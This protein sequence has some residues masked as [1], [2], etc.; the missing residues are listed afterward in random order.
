MFGLLWRVQRDLLKLASASYSGDPALGCR[1]LWR[2]L[3]HPKCGQKIRHALCATEPQGSMY[4]YC[5][6]FGLDTLGPTYILLAYM[7]P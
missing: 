6:Y 1:V 2:L 5:I 3:L 7:Y 4:S